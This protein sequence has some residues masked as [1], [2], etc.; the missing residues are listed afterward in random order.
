MSKKTEVVIVPKRLRKPIIIPKHV[1]EKRRE[2]VHQLYETIRENDIKEQ[3]QIYAD[4]KKNHTST[5]SLDLLYKILEKNLAKVLMRV[6]EIYSTYEEDPVIELEDVL[7]KKDGKTLEDRVAYWFKKYPKNNEIPFLFHRLWIILNTEKH[8]I[9]S[10]V[11][12]RKT[13]VEYIEVFRDSVDCTTGICEEYCD[14]EAHHIDEWEEP[15]YHANCMCEAVFYEEYDL[16]PD[17]PTI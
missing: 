4:L 14:E 11:I 1:K 15:P 7:F 3:E 6:Q 17:D 9:V 8:N 10:Q 12:K 13:K 2:E 5:S 16:N